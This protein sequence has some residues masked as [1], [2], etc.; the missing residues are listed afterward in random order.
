MTVK[1]CRTTTYR[2]TNIDKGICSNQP[3]ANIVAFV[4]LQETQRSGEECRL[5]KARRYINCQG[6]SAEYH[7]LQNKLEDCN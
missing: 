5:S 7:T 2:K 1:Q 6:N 3:I 4:A